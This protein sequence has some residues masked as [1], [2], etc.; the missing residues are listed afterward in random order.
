MRPCSPT[1]IV[2]STPSRRYKAW[3]RC[4][5]DYGEKSEALEWAKDFVLD[6]GIMEQDE[7]NLH[8]H[9]GD[10]VALVKERLAG[11]SRN[12]FAKRRRGAR[13]CA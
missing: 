7:T 13:C 5:Q 10:F 8:R 4:D 12:P 1:T 6:Y 3:R 2:K 9:G 11:L